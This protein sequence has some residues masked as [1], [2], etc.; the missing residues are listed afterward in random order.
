MNTQYKCYSEL[1][2]S[3]SYSGGMYG[4]LTKCE[5]KITVYLFN[6]QKKEL[7]QYPAILTEQAWSLKDLLYGIKHQRMICVL[8]GQS[9]YHERA[10]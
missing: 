6:M 3:I 1:I 8:A 10:R 2:Q 4:L 5:V 7:R 9:L